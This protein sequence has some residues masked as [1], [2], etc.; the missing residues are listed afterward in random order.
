MF[1]VFEK[2]SLEKL[3]VVVL[4]VGLFALFFIVIFIQPVSLDISE[5]GE[6][7]IGKTVSINAIVKNKILRNGN[8][9]LDVFDKANNESYI[10]SVMFENDIRRFNLSDIQKGSNVNIIG[11]VDRYMGEIEIIIKKIKVIY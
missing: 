11:K 5:I 7:D 3:C 6:D 8:L 9:F 2:I 1:E 4:V 10:K